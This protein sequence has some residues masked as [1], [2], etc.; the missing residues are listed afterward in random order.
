M[1]DFLAVKPL[2]PIV[3]IG[4]G[5]AGITSA[6]E[7]A[8]RGF[9][10]IIVDKRL[11][12]SRKQRVYLD[13][14]HLQYLELDSSMAQKPININ[15]IQK[16]LEKMLQSYPNVRILKGPNYQVT[17]IH[18]DINYITISGPGSTKEEI[19][20]S[21]LVGADGSTHTIADL[22]SAAAKQDEETQNLAITYRDLPQ[23]TPHAFHATITLRFNKPNLTS[24]QNNDWKFFV[25]T[26]SLKN[27]QPLEELG[28]S[29]ALPP[30]GETF[31]HE[32]KHHF[33]VGCE[34]PE[35]LFL[36]KD[37]EVQKQKLIK[38]ATLII[39]REYT[40]PT[41]AELELA[42]SGKS[43]EKSKAKD[44]LK[45]TLFQIKLQY[46][47]K[48]AVPLPSGGAFVLVGDASMG[49]YYMKAHGVN[50]AMNDAM[51]FGNRLQRTAFDYITYN[52][53]QSNKRKYLDKFQLDP[54]D[55]LA[56]HTS[57][58]KNMIITDVYA[59]LKLSQQYKNITDLEQAK[60]DCDEKIRWLSR[61]NV[62]HLTDIHKIHAF[63]LA[64][65]HLHQLLDL[66]KQQA[67]PPI[68]EMPPLPR[69]CK[70]YLQLTKQNEKTSQALLF[71][72]D[73]RKRIHS[74]GD[75]SN[76]KKESKHT[77]QM[78]KD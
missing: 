24:V 14:D 26:K 30:L 44:Q 37:P 29:S 23:Q 48:S 74:P 69:S 34:I 27:M 53:Y 54:D 57:G 21:H 50:L 55:Y 17:E 41:E 47:E 10:V 16:R 18:P 3:I 2:K 15:T 28:W 25:R 12:Y 68:T 8:R 78:K 40:L 51:N 60:N 52:E 22:F 5:P 13:S 36:E 6:I 66:H 9:P 73:N 49:T 38:W 46:A 43:D 1:K 35:T 32:E 19:E 7:A 75:E 45:Y 4:M 56:S 31:Y 11:H 71:S 77:H 33:Y 65:I 39:S 72:N 62:T 61:E 67:V 58:H 70:V 59:L 42:V 63:Y 64:V 76:T 20:F